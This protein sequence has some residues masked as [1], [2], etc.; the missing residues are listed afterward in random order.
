[1]YVSMYPGVRGCCFK[2][3]MLVLKVK[4]NI[5]F[6]ITFR[7]EMTNARAHEKKKEKK[8]EQTGVDPAIHR[9]HYC[10]HSHSGV[11]PKSG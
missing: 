9:R 7:S 3:K 10:D 5:L 4:I 1:M 11:I 8:N 6:H 2:G